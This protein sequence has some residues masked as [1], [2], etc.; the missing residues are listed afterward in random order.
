MAYYDLALLQ[1]DQ[2]FRQR[3]AAAYSLELV[4]DGTLP[5]GNNDPWSWVSTNAWAIAAA[6]GFADAYAYALAADP[7]NPAPGKDPGVITDGMILA[8]VQ[9]ILAPPPAQ[10]P[11]GA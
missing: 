4:A 8:A 10:E 6:P 9:A 5:A 7:P 2:D 1:Q 11:L 3:V